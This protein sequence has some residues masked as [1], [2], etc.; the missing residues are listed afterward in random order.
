MGTVDAGGDVTSARTTRP[1]SSRT[2]RVDAGR[3][4]REH[5][6]RASLRRSPTCPER[7]GLHDEVRYADDQRGRPRCRSAAD[8]GALGTVGH[9]YQFKGATDDGRSRLGRRRTTRTWRVWTDLTTAPTIAD[10]Y[11]N[12][13]NLTKST[14]ARSASW[15]LMNDV[16]AKSEAYLDNVAST[17][18]ATSRSPPTR[19]RRSSPRRRAPS[20]RPAAPSSAPAPCR[21]STARWSRTSCWLPRPRR[22]PTATSRP[23]ATSP[24]SA[25]NHSGIDATL[26][27]ATSS[28][29]PPSAITLAFNSIGWQSQNILFNLIDTLLG[30]PLSPRA[31]NGE[32]P[33][34]VW[35]RSPTRRSTPTAASSSRPTAPRS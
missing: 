32:E 23:R 27:V 16:R 3:D 1:G 29:D 5:R 17:R 2:R 21:R 31:L 11:P 24:S 8:D 12:L 10:F 14:R 28:G 4:R 25:A 6:C 30:D 15:S 34:L 19:R 26:L 22:S 20:P 18:P 33:S 9:V 7:R 13:G 35:R